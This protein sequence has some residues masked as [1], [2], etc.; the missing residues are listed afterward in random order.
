MNISMER[1]VS[2][3]IFCGIQFLTNP[4]RFWIGCG[5]GWGNAAHAD[6]ERGDRIEARKTILLSTNHASRHVFVSIP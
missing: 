5:V 2:H 4:F 6:I 3:W 1:L